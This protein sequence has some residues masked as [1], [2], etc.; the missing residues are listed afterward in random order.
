MQSMVVQR[1]VFGALLIAAVAAVIW[2][3]IQISAN[4]SAAV[5]GVDWRCGSLIPGT[6][7]GVY[8]A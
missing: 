7:S 4:A 6:F 3:D 8:G 2:G 1:I 5:D